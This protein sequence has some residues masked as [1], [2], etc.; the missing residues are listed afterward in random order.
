M[1][2]YVHIYI[3]T[4]IVIFQSE[5]SNFNKVRDQLKD[6]INTHSNALYFV[7]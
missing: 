2:A 5:I 4:Y 3:H 7:I 6:K 1:H